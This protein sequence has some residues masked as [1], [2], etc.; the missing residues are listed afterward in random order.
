MSAVQS[1]LEDWVAGESDKYVIYPAK[2]DIALRWLNEGQLRFCDRSEMLRSV[3]SPT[4]DATGIIS[5]PS[6]FLREI[7]DLVKWAPNWPLWEMDYPKA[8]LLT[9]SSPR[10]YSIWGNKMYIWAPAAG[11]PT[12]PYMRKP[13]VLTSDKNDDLEIPTEYQ[14]ALTYYLESKWLKRNKDV[15]G[16]LAMLRTFDQMADEAAARYRARR[17]P[18]PMMRGSFF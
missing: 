1:V 8:S 16:S 7:K 4:I 17:D 14:N 15:A 6:D 2:Q 3:W 18:V 5:L 10:Y 13:R 9:F 11:S 12:I